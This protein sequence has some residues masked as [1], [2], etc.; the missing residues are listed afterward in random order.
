M[1]APIHFYVNGRAASCSAEESDMSLLEF[2]HERLHLSGTKFG[3]GAG[4]C[5]ACT[6][7]LKRPGQ[8]LE[9]ASACSLQVSAL[10]GVEVQTVEGLGNADAL[11]PLQ[12]AF[13]DHFAFQCGY[14]TPGFLMAAS[15]L[16]A[17][18]KQKPVPAAQLD[19]L[20]LQALGENICRCTGYVRYLDAVRE[21]AR[22][23]VK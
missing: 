17:R 3:C 8:T 19:Q 7:A 15:V 2:L 5:R 20:I 14:C 10:A 4:L 18:L 9:K 11:A 21:V 13:L 22:Q 16:L 6:V 1:S 23:Y 12:Q